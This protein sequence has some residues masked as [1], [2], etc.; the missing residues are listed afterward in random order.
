M[1]PAGEATELAFYA[2]LRGATTIRLIKLGP[3]STSQPIVASLITVDSAST[4]QY[5]AISYVWGNPDATINII[6]DGRPMPITINLH[7][8][9]IHV[10]KPDRPS[11]I[12]ADAICINQRDVQERSH[13]VSMVG[14]IYANARTVYL[15][16]G[17]DPDGGASN[18]LSILKE[19][20]PYVDRRDIPAFLQSENIKNDKRW[21][22]AGT[23]TRQPWFERAWVLQ[24]AGLADNPRVYYG[25]VEFSYRDLI[26]VLGCLN[27]CRWG[28]RYGLQTWLIVR[29]ETS[30]FAIT[31]YFSRSF[32][33]HYVATV[34]RPARSR[35]Q[36]SRTS[37]G[38][39]Q[40]RIR[41][42]CATR[43]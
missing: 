42:D 41:V 21:F 2:K 20:K 27:P 12:W 24:E 18:V 3:G 8:A 6:C 5:N 37:F 22:A 36:L 4:L 40:R 17:D 19:A 28:D 25:K 1:T 35:L 30:T 14:S 32:M 15:C 38:T 23:L 11:V 7:W 33:P 34:P 13:Q 29:L 43:L 10:R 9:L 16:M 39:T 26:A 31:V